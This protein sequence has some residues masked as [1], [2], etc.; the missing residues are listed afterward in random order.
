MI[1]IV[2]ITPH[3]GGGVGTVLTS[4]LKG[5]AQNGDFQQTLI[6]LEYI[7]K[8][9]L[10]QFNAIGIDYVSEIETNSPLIQQ[11]VREADI[12]HIHFWNHPMLFALLHALNGTTGRV[13]LWAH[14]NGHF[15]PYLFSE[16]IITFGEIFAVTSP[17]SL[18]QKVLDRKEQIWKSEHLRVI[19]STAGTEQFSTI[20]HLY[21]SAVQ[22]GYIGTVDYAKI[23]RE[24]ISLFLSIRHTPVHFHICGGNQHVQI[25]QEVSLNG[26]SDN[27]TF[28]GPID[29]ISKV[30]ATL[31]IFAYPLNRNNYGTGE[32]VLIEAMSAGIPQVVLSGGP[33]EFVVKH[34]VTGFVCKNA[35]EFISAI[36]T[37]CNDE[38]LRQS[39]S[40]AS[41]E[42]AQNYCLSHEVES[43][44]EL[45]RDLLHRD[46]KVLQFRLY[47]SE[48]Y[49]Y[50]VQ[51]FLTGLGDCEE[52]DLCIEALSFYPGQIPA[53]L[54]NRLDSLPEIF[55]SKTKGSIHH[56]TTFFP[57]E[58]SKYLAMLLKKEE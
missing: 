55:H 1:S 8:K 48:Q 44:L 56:Y 27:W 52:R 53:E 9:S 39:M 12:V 24:F 14:V 28:Y 38:R 43:W 42:H 7:N 18:S 20:T 36:E 54:Q 31:D 21:S 13:V 26:S 47:D 51:L 33:E 45:Y 34:N 40:N 6:S 22:I 46:K 15:P 4:L 41:R 35:E 17:F 37:L 3:L 32:Q 11:R 29:D 23:H 5:I 49:D 10:D 57:S 2:H 30:L 19:H 16:E 25:E 58:Q 50:S